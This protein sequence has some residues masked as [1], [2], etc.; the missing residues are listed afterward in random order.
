MCASCV[1]DVVT[2][3]SFRHHNIMLSSLTHL[4]YAASIVHMHNVFK[5][6]LQY[7]D[8]SVDRNNLFDDLVTSTGT[9]FVS[10]H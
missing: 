5:I 7:I 9:I 3:R 6:Q 1:G 4:Y 2:Q 10:V 8:H